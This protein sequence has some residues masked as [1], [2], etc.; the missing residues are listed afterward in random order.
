MNYINEGKIILLSRNEGKLKSYD[1]C[2]DIRAWSHDIRDRDHYLR[3]WMKCN[4]PTCIFSVST[5]NNL[6]KSMACRHFSR[7]TP[8]CHPDCKSRKLLESIC[9]SCQAMKECL[10]N[11]E[12]FEK[13]LEE[14]EL[15]TGHW[16]CDKCLSVLKSIKMF[17]KVILDKILRVNI[18]KTEVISED[19]SN[20]REVIHGVAKDWQKEILE[21]TT[22]VKN[23]I[24]PI[25]N[26]NVL[27]KQVKSAKTDA[28]MSSS[29]NQIQN[30]I[31]TPANLSFESKSSE[32]KCNCR[33]LNKNSGCTLTSAVKLSDTGCDPL[34]I[35]YN[36]KLK[37]YK[38]YFKK[39][40]E[41]LQTQ[42]MEVKELKKENDALKYKLQEMRKKPSLKTLYAP[43]ALSPICDVNQVLEPF[44]P[45]SEENLNA[46][47]TKETNSE[48]I[49]TLKN[50]KNENFKHVCML[51][52]VHKTNMPTDEFTAEEQG[53]FKEKQD[54]IVLLNKVQKTFGNIVQKELINANKK[55]NSAKTQDVDAT[56]IRNT[57]CCKLAPSHTTTSSC[58]SN[59]S[60]TDHV[61]KR[62]VR[63]KNTKKC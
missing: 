9:T 8:R 41:Q 22:F 61:I 47:S 49:I 34:N 39:L 2:F 46:D 56:L 23:F 60:E 37:S 62:D 21:Q 16:P 1:S 20:V 51:Q 45:C 40:Q 48:V 30:C 5:L 4:M 14:E 29:Q 31:N 3:E 10:K 13:Y 26:N 19:H 36:E 35:S 32:S 54:P 52:V 50:C 15:E 38:Y 44:E 18:P 12:N 59:H 55:Q 58:W 63:S 6:L 17:W 42:V 43:T 11:N 33:L 57:N 25:T 28:N 7:L 24:S 53:C 27:L